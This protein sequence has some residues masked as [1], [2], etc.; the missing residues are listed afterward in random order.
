MSKPITFV[1]SLLDDI[2]QDLTIIDQSEVKLE[3]AVARLDPHTPS[4]E[5]MET[6]KQLRA[7][8]DRRREAVLTVLDLADREIGKTERQKRTKK[9]SL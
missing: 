4:P 8:I 6:I 1:Q 5:D 7:K 9:E 2:Y 3:T